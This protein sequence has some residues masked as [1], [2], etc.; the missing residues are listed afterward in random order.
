M[1]GAG[2]LALGDFEVDRLGYGAMR[3]TGPRHLGP[4]SR[5]PDGPD[6]AIALL[7]RAAR[8]RRQLLRHRRFLRAQ[9]Q[10]G[11]DRR[12]ARPLRRLVVA[13]KGGMTRLA[14]VWDADG[15]PEH[16]RD[17][18]EG[19]LRRLS[20]ASSTSTSSIVPTR[21]C[22]FEESLGA[23]VEA[24][25]RARSATSDSRTSR[26]SSSRWRSGW[27]R[28]SACRTATDPAS[29]PLSRSSRPA[30][31]SGSRS[32]RH[33][34]SPPVRPPT[35]RDHSRRLP[36]VTARPPARSRSPG[37]WRYR[38]RCCRF[39]DLAD[40]P[41]ERERRRRRDPPERQAISSAQSSSSRSACGSLTGAGS[42]SARRRRRSR[43]RRAPCVPA[44]GR[45]PS[46][47]ASVAAASTT[48]GRW[49]SRTTSSSGSARGPTSATSRTPAVCRSTAHSRCP[50]AA[51]KRGAAPRRG[52]RAERRRFVGALAA[53][54]GRA[55]AAPARRS[56]SPR[57]SVDPRGP[58]DAR[59]AARRR[60]R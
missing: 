8:A 24:R 34:R 20:R 9:R 30:C 50:N 55:A 32:S 15:R 6:G 36:A 27:R 59:S 44:A 21:R 56:R 28:S 48:W 38:R 46:L 37:C 43:G 53:Q 4:P 33:S 19:S 3:I 23:L 60:L 26:S 58:C 29:W 31:A 52:D 12:G 39:L 35:R 47:S 51:G 17:A 54:C 41:L 14:P 11:A 5:P 25:G 2:T 40:R 16:L 1:S 42:R 18:I 49:R 45:S 7:R 10:R 57:V 22:R 13:T